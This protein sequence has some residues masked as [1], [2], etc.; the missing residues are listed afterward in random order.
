MAG[1]V[2]TVCVCSFLFF[3]LDNIKLVRF[4]DVILTRSFISIC[5]YVCALE[6]LAT[7]TTAPLLP[8]PEN[9]AREIYSQITYPANQLPQNLFF[10]I[11]GQ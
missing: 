6:L 3:L 2:Y 10:R 4:R 1:S 7:P 9:Q 5:A 8:A 11:N